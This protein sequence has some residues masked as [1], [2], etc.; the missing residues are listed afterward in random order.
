MRDFHLL[1]KIIIDGYGEACKE[2]VVTVINT[3]LDLFF[4]L[5]TL[6]LTSLIKTEIY[7]NEIM[8]TKMLSW[9]N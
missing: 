7:D 8:T 1:N 6:A 4:C 3:I 2:Q 9:V 5:C